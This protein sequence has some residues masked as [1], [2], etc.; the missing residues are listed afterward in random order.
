M[1]NRLENLHYL[2]KKNENNSLWDLIE[3]K[4]LNIDDTDVGKIESEIDRLEKELNDFQARIDQEIALT[5]KITETIKAR[6]INPTDMNV[7]RDIELQWRTTHSNVENIQRM[8][9]PRIDKI[10]KLREKMVQEQKN[11]ILRLQNECYDMVAM[12]ITN[13]NEGMEHI[14]NALSHIFQS[15]KTLI[16]I[17]KMKSEQPRQPILPN[18]V[19]FYDVF[20]QVMNNYIDYLNQ[21]I[22]K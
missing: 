10:Q 21:S 5:E 16:E 9:Q 4:E 12:G 20:E 6:A 3:P 15:Q 7:M 17:E 13:I 22:K 14:K 11:L 1:E 8:M 18:P 19:D 2:D